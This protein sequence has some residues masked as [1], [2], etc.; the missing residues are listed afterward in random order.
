MPSVPISRIAARWSLQAA[1]VRLE[2]HLA[3]DRHAELHRRVAE[4]VGV[5]A[6]GRA[7]F[8]EQPDLLEPLLVQPVG[9][10]DAFGGDVA[11]GDGEAV[12][13]GELVGA[14]PPDD[15]HADAV[16]RRL[17]RDAVVG[18]QR[19]EDHDAALV[20]QPLVALDHLAVVLARQAAGVGDDELDRA[21]APDAFVQA[22]STARIDGIEPVGQQLAEIHVDEHADLDRLEGS[23]C[24]ATPRV[25][26]YTTIGCTAFSPTAPPPSYHASPSPPAPCWYAVVPR[27]TLHTARSGCAI[28]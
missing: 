24:V 8:P 28:P 7:R 22:S 4:V 25:G 16:D 17:E 11:V 9:A 23:P 13:A 10:H 3:R 2:H 14:R 1:G 20:D 5:V 21:A 15:R 18:D 12:V 19:S 6:A 26:G 27:R